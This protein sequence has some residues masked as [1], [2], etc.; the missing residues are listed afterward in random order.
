MKRLEI[1][2][3]LYPCHMTMGAMLRFKRATGRDVQAID[4]TNTED[5]LHLLHSCFAS[6][7]KAEG[8]KFEY[9]MEEMADHLTADDIVRFSNDVFS[10]SESND[11]T[12]AK[13][14]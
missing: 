4:S 9:T 7:S 3:V 13:K 1:N 11:D 8:V 2:G 10:A 5:V 6:A 14:K 12:D